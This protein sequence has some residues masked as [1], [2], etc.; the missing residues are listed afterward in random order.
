MSFLVLLFNDPFYSLSVLK[1]STFMSVLSVIF[2]TQFIAYLFFFWILGAERILREE[3]SPISKILTFPKKVL[4]SAYFISYLVVLTWYYSGIA[5]SSYE[6]HFIVNPQQISPGL[7]FVFLMWLIINI[8]I[9]G[10]LVLR[11]FQV[12]GAVLWRSKIWLHFNFY[13][14]LLLTIFVIVTGSIY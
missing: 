6:G 2:L 13:F 5:I 11:I 9:Y 7:S 8:T 12:E 3:G 14:A 4:Y 10:W 1:P